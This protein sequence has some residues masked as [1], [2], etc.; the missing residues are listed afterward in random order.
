MVPASEYRALEAQVRELQRLL[1]KKAMEKNLLR[2]VLFWAA[3]PKRLF[4]SSTSVPGC[5]VTVGADALGIASPHLSATRNQPPL[6]PR[7]RLQLPDAE[8]VADIRL[9]VAGLPT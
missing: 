7:G 5:S 2:P 6:R 1:H 8:L 3:G 9:L 4:V